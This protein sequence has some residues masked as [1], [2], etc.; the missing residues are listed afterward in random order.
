L[1]TTVTTLRKKL[2]KLD[3]LKRSTN[4]SIIALQTKAAS[5]EQRAV[6]LQTFHDTHQQNIFNILNNTREF[7]TLTALINNETNARQALSEKID[8]TKAENIGNRV[9]KM[10]NHIGTIQRIEN[11]YWIQRDIIN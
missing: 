7:A 6:D 9:I 5:L 11:R 2:G 3:D 10:K 4:T 1:E 8:L